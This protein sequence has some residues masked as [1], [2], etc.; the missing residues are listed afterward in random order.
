MMRPAR[1][2]IECDQQHVSVFVT[3]FEAAVDCYTQK[4]GFTLA[5][6]WGEPA[7]FA[8]VNL[9]RVQIFLDAVQTR[10]DR[11]LP[12]LQRRPR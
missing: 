1:P 12:V 10:S 8:G 7:S 2:L 6:K 5:F 9:D 3:D 4:L 11:V